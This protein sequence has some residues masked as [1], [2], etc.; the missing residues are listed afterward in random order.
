KPEQK[1]NLLQRTSDA[2]V[3]ALQA[4]LP[5]VR[6]VLHELPAGH[7]LNGGRFDTMA[8]QFEID[9]V[10]GRSEQAKLDLMVALDRAARDTTDVPDDEVRVRISDF[11]NTDLGMAQGRSAKQMGR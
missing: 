5:S 6:V 7:Y 11:P 10:A 4:P 3:Q 1:K 8:I 9:M 2:V